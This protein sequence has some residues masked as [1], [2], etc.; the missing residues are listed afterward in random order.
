MTEEIINL[1]LKGSSSIVAFKIAALAK[2]IYSI[3]L[4]INCLK[5]PGIVLYLTIT[6]FVT[7]INYLSILQ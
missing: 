7:P 3:S 5:G 4:F 2:I 1:L 6:N